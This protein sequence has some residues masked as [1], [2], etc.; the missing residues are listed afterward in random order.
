MINIIP[1][2]T[3]SPPRQLPQ[4]TAPGL[5]GERVCC[6]PCLASLGVSLANVRAVASDRASRWSGVETPVGALGKAN[7]DVCVWVHGGQLLLL[8]SVGLVGRGLCRCC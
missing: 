2:C 6:P 7:S 4:A 3:V 5:S 1:L 8:A